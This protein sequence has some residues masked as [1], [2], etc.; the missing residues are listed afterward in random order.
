MIPFLDI[1]VPDDF[2]LLALVVVSVGGFAW[3]FC[4]LFEE[5]A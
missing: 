4:K 3:C 1:E 5:Q 2:L